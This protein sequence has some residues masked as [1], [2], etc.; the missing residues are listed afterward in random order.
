MLFQEVNISDQ[1]FIQFAVNTEIYNEC[2]AG[3]S[4]WELHVL[5]CL[6]L[7]DSGLS[8]P[9]MNLWEI[10]E[11]EMKQTPLQSKGHHW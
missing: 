7:Y 3:L 4:Y 9:K 6:Y 11:A 2:H 8:W 1:S 5:E 10:R